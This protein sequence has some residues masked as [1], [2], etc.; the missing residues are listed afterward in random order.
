MK[1]KVQNKT[2]GLVENCSIPAVGGSFPS[3]EWLMDVIDEVVDNN[4][5]LD[6]ENIADSIIE[7]WEKENESF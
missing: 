3:R 1:R 7:Q 6:S 5:T 2:E 4:Q